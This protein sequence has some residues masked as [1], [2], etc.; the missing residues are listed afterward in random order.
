M[1]PRTTPGPHRANHLGGMPHDPWKPPTVKLLYT[2]IHHGNGGGHVTYLMSLMRGLKDRHDITLLCPPGGRLFRYASELDGVRVLPG[3]YTSR[4]PALVREVVGLRRFLARERFDLVHVSASAD[5]R[6]MMLARAGMSR[7]PAIVWTRH[8]L[9]RIHSAGHRLRARFGTDAVIAVSQFV[10]DDISRSAYGGLP[11]H[12]IRHGI[13]TRHYAPVPLPRKAQLQQVLLGEAAGPGK[14]VLGSTG[15]TDLAKGW[16][17]LLH[18]VARLPRPQQERLVLV[19][20]GDPPGPVQQQAMRGIVHH[21]RLVFPGLVDDIRQVLGAC[22]A[23][24]VLS[25]REALSYAARESLAMGLPTL[26]SNAGGLPEN[27]VAGEHG[28]I[29]PVGDAD[30]IA[31]VLAAWLNDPALCERQ[32]RA[33]RR[34]AETHFAL[35]GFLRATDA[36]Y[37]SVTL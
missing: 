14:L 13:D 24:F 5:H 23:G 8:N 6:H 30:A 15:G 20:A 21:A 3:L 19:V 1:R 10:A 28:D 34:H 26:V 37:R 4:L 2:D 27:L 31:A 25:H 18:G 36:V 35:D 17:D 29:V 22:D 7:R 33:A 12:V 32:G 11:C 16:V 9:H